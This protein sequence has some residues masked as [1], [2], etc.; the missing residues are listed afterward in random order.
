M[1]QSEQPNVYLVGV[2]PGDPKLLTVKAKELIDNADVIIY[3]RLVSQ[4]IQDLFPPKARCIYVGKNP[5]GDSVSQSDIHNVLLQYAHPDKT[6]VRLKGGDPFVFGRGG[7][8]ALFL[9]QHDID[10]QIVPGITSAIAVAEYA[11]IPVTHRGISTSFSV[12]TGHTQDES[13]ID[14]YPWEHIAHGV[15]TLVILMGIRNLPTIV[16]HLLSVGKDKNTPV[17]V[18]EEGTTPHQ[19]TVVGT[20]ENIQS[21]VYEENIHPPSIIVIG[22]T[23]SLRTSISWFDQRPLWN[24]TILVTRAKDQ[25]SPLRERLKHLGANVVSIPS[26]EIR[27]LPLSD[28]FKNDLHSIS[29]FSWILF[30]SVN[31]VKIFFEELSQR[32]MDAR[33]L[34]SN[35]IA[36]IGPSTKEEIEKHGIVP[37]IIPVSF[38][39]ESLWEA[40]KDRIQP[41]DSVLFPRAKNARP[42]LIDTLE[43]S[44]CRVHEH[45]LYEAVYETKCTDNQIEKLFSQKLDAITFTSA[46]C[47]HGFFQSLPSTM[48]NIP[49]NIPCICIGPITAKAAKNHG[50]MEPIVSEEYTIK[51]LCD[52]IVQILKPIKK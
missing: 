49:S 20:L 26:I 51:G 40:L 2:G 16:S 23:V 35:Q 6:I 27:R 39:A 18:I 36:C 11:G 24:K 45:H 13:S 21:R 44:Q 28:S 30:S 1:R 4:E 43:K 32:N 9:K 3:D 25:E 15:D 33:A 22:K 47:V 14:D 41:G 10:F 17:A 8:E 19:R 50:V 5:N 38:V 46:S 12:I 48:T 42:F 34:H 37:D 7:E 31:S 29:S 52:T